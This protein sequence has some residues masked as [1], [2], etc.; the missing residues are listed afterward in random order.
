MFRAAVRKATGQ[1][2]V[3]LHHAEHGVEP[4]GAAAVR[5][6]AAAVLLVGHVS[7]AILAL[8][9]VLPAAHWMRPRNFA[10]CC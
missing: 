6:A 4:L 10:G 7:A 3:Q 1:L 2:L 8:Q 9:Q 5:A